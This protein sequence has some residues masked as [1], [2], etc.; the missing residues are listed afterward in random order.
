M[1]TLVNTQ[2]GREI[3]SGD[4]ADVYAAVEA[5]APEYNEQIDSVSFG[6]DQYGSPVWVRYTDLALAVEMK[7]AEYKRNY[8]KYQTKKG[9]YNADTKTVVVYVQ[10]DDQ[11]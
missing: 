6:N 1:K 7:Y 10:D 8:A 4:W 2:T 5:L 11:I 3:A 9:S